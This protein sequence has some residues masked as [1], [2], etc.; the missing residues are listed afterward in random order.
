MSLLD[1][2]RVVAN[3]TLRPNKFTA[4]VLFPA[5][6]GDIVDLAEACDIAV[7]EAE[8]PS[9]A[10]GVIDLPKRGNPHSI[11]GNFQKPADITLTF[12]NIQGSGLR[13]AFE[14]WVEYMASP[15]AGT[16][17]NNV[18]VFGE[19]SIAQ[20]N[21]VDAVVKTYQLLYAFPNNI[22]NIALS[23]ESQDQVETFSVTFT[24]SIPV[25]DLT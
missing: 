7:R 17:A 24:Y 18:T 8:L 1:K 20:L 16:V 5:P 3:E 15:V 10:V 23:E 11:P 9:R 21:G 14:R 25:T 4:K 22:S 13:E 12:L 2:F 6:V 19:V